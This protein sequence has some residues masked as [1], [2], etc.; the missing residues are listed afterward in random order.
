[1]RPEVD[2]KAKGAT[3]DQEDQEYILKQMKKVCELSYLEGGT[4]TT[5]KPPFRRPYVCRPENKY[6]ML[7]PPV[8]IYCRL[9]GYYY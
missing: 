2:I 3:L 1:M 8:H 9:K 5:V 4:T 6:F 7:L